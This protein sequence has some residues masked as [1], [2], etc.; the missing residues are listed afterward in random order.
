MDLNVINDEK[1]IEAITRA[2]IKTFEE[3][4]FIQ[5]IKADKTNNKIQLN[6]CYQIE[7]IDPITATLYLRLD[8]ELKNKIAENIYSNNISQLT[9]YSI[10]D[11]IEELLNILAGNILGEYFEDFMKY[12]LELPQ[13]IC[14]SI[15]TD[16]MKEKIILAFYTEEDYQL[17]IIFILERP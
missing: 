7:I 6:N 10:S 13:L 11:C 8:D 12:K 9:N 4:A 17:Q 5:I 1:M 15:E 14:N 3:M 2:A 16:T